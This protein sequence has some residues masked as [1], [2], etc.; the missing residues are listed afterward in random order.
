MITHNFFPTALQES[1]I[2]EWLIHCIRSV[3]AVHEHL[4]M[5][6]FSGSDV[7]KCPICSS[8]ATLFTYRATYCVSYAFT[9]IL[10]CGWYVEIHAI[11]SVRKKY[12]K[13]TIDGRAAIEF[14]D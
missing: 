11:I 4:F 5:I 12:S 3:Y 6:E 9:Y 14:Q 13:S 2:Y 8:Y 7:F 1:R 10:P